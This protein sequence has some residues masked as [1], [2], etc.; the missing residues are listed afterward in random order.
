M[1]DA[2]EL[3]GRLSPVRRTNAAPMNPLDDAHI[4]GSA[5]E[6]TSES[7]LNTGF[8]ATSRGPSTPGTKGRDA[9]VYALGEH[10]RNVSMSPSSL[11][12]GNNTGDR[13]EDIV[14]APR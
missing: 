6:S 5:G 7:S 1:R 8:P 11:R 2:D 12:Y 13:L 9:V 4:G 14:P 10:V 3:G